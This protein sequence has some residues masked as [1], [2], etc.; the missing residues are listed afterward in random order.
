MNW[1]KLLEDLQL[2]WPRKAILVSRHASAGSEVRLAILFTLATPYLK[3]HF[4][5]MYFKRP[6]NRNRYNI[7]GHYPYCYIAFF[8]SVSISMFNLTRPCSHCSDPKFRLRLLQYVN[9][10]LISLYQILHMLYIHKDRV[11]Y[12][13]WYTFHFLDK[14]FVYAIFKKWPF[15]ADLNRKHAAWPVHVPVQYCSVWTLL[16]IYA[17]GPKTIDLTFA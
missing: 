6:G 13:L 7:V 8:L 3:F 17:L 1:R 15:I 5:Y 9:T 4:I 16:R 14:N 11:V 10:I 12:I 2:N